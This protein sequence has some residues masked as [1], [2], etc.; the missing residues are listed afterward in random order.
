VVSSHGDV[1]VSTFGDCGEDLLLLGE[2]AAIDND[3][4]VDKGDSGIGVSGAVEHAG[5]V[6]VAEEDGGSESSGNTRVNS[7]D[8]LSS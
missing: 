5:V 6:S 7:F 3:V 1:T 4:F 8:S 2:V